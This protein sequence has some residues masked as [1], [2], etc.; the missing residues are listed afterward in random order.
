MA[1][2]DQSSGDHTGE[3]MTVAD[4]KTARRAA[5]QNADEA[6]V[7]RSIKHLMQEPHGPSVIMTFTPGAAKMILEQL[8]S[9]NRPRKSVKVAEFANYMTAGNWKLTGDTVKFSNLYLRDGQNRME[10]CVRSGV[11]FT[12]HVVFGL[13]D[14]IFTFLDNGK[15]RTVGDAFAI[16]GVENP[17]TVAGAVR[18]LEKFRTNTVKDRSGLTQNEGVNAFH[19]H[20]DSV[21]MKV[22]VAAA[23]A[24]SNAD[25]TPKTIA[26]ALHYLFADKN[27]ALANE[28]FEAWAARN[29]GG[30]MRPIKKAS[31]YLAALNTA[32]NGRVHEL[33]RISAW[34]VAWNLVVQRRVGRKP[35][36]RWTP[37]DAVPR[38]RG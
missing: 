34:I 29:W 13:D 17:T 18:W 16:E 33:A 20:Y 5:K 19:E 7:E 26:A 10:A 30:R 24:V 32:S 37:A 31:D 25:D 2:P 36:F 38:I 15:P 8:N 11:P 22:S 9:N 27:P 1:R 6:F 12:T 4:L 14:R 28:F 3:A 35:D 21:R 23:R